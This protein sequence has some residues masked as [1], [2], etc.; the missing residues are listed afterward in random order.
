MLAL[1]L[2]F[3]FITPNAFAGPLEDGLAAYN[4]KDYATTLRLWR[5]MAEQ[6]DGGVQNSLGYMYEK[7]RG[8]PQDQVQAHRFYRLAAAGSSPEFA[9]DR[10]QAAKNRDRLANEITLPD[11]PEGRLLAKYICEADRAASG[12]WFIAKD[13]NCD[14]SLTISDVKLW[15]GWLFFLPGDGL[16]YSLLVWQGA[17]IFLE[18][19]PAIYGGWV[20]GILSAVLWLGMLMAAANND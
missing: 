12:R 18:L 7:V 3:G 17:A 20:A 5:P 2:W 10:A 13:M 8:V 16:L 14:G 19:T 9:E 1:M 15:L 11:T 6:G 4:E